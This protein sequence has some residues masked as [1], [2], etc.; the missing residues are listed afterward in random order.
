MNLAR[1][2]HWRLLWCS[3]AD[4]SRVTGARRLLQADPGGGAGNATAGPFAEAIQKGVKKVV[5]AQAASAK[6]NAE[7]AGKNEAIKQAD[8]AYHFIHKE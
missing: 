4:L 7:L 1:N 5:E 2:G 8:I 6:K 3:C